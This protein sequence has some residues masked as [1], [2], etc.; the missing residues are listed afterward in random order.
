MFAIPI[1]YDLY[2]CKQSFLCCYRPK[3][4]TKLLSN[5]CLD[6]DSTYLETEAMK[7]FY[8]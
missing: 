5:S 6:M 3:S 7:F 8:H 4:R 1:V 2:Y